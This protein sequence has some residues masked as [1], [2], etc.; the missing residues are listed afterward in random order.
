MKSFK[1]FK[2]YIFEMKDNT[3]ELYG[4]SLHKNV[5]LIDVDVSRRAG[6]KVKGI[7]VMGAIDMKGKNRT[8]L[9]VNSWD[10]AWAATEGLTLKKGE[11]LARLESSLTKVSKGNLENAGLVKFNVL[12]CTITFIKD[13]DAEHPVWSKAVR[14]RRIA[15]HEPFIKK[16]D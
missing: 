14:V 2:E 1:E 8:L 7:Y 9:N 3:G 6:D 15:I 10:Y 13:Y 11:Y 16:I 4:M 12:T 5:D